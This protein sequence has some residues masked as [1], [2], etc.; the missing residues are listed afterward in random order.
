MPVRR[1]IDTNVLVYTDDLDALA[2]Q[3]RSLEIVE[4]VRL[5]GSGVVSTQVLQEYFVTATRKLHVDGAIA[6]RKVELFSRLNLAEIGLE[7]ILGAIDVHRLYRLSFWD[8]LI[9]R[10]ALDSGCSELL[11]EDLSPDQ[12]F[13]GLRIVNPFA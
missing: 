13:H 1:F 6:R 2:K 9:V 11:T 4:T 7:T 3:Q 5:D 8:A 10:T 12:Q